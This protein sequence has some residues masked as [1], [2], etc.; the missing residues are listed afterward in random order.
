VHSI[1]RMQF[2]GLEF[3][4]KPEETYHR[5]S[6]LIALFL[7]LSRPPR[8]QKS[9]SQAATSRIGTLASLFGSVDVSVVHWARSKPCVQIWPQICASVQTLLPVLDHPRLFSGPPAIELRSR[10]PQAVAQPVKFDHRERFRRF[11]GSSLTTRLTPPL[12]PLFDLLPAVRP[13]SHLRAHG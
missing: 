7:L 5:F 3:I 10:M 4:S 12:L 2:T 6:L 9:T 1:A 13:V 11:L 8:S